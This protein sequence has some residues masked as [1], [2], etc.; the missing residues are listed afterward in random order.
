[1]RKIS[2]QHLLYKVRL[3]FFV[4][5][6]PM[7]NLEKIAFSMSSVIS[8]PMIVPSSFNILRISEVRNSGDT[9]FLSPLIR[10]LQASMASERARLC[11]KVVMTTCSLEGGPLFQIT[12]SMHS[13]SCSKPFPSLAEIN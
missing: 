12:L 9:P 5:H 11:L 1:M 3:F 4:H 13:R 10:S 7:Q 6:F 2:L 8:V